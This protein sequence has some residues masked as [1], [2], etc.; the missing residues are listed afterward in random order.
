MPPETNLASH[1][2]SVSTNEPHLQHE[3]AA[4]VQQAPRVHGLLQ[5][6]LLHAWVAAY[7]DAP[8]Q[9]NTHLSRWYDTHLGGVVDDAHTCAQSLVRILAPVVPYRYGGRQA[10][11]NTRAAAPVMPV[12]CV[13]DG[14]M[15]VGFAAM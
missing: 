1:R 3:Q 7:S 9:C 11:K 10:S 2:A 4:C 14:I 15:E 6:N 5:A 12:A 13:H 8:G